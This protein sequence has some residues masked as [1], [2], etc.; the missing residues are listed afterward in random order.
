[1]HKNAF[2]LPKG[3]CCYA[4]VDSPCAD[5]AICTFAETSFFVGVI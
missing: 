3:F 1:M 2:L 5:A 4:V